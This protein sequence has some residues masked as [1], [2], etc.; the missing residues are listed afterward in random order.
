MSICLFFMAILIY[1]IVRGYR[2]LSTRI[3]LS[4]IYKHLQTIQ[5]LIQTNKATIYFPLLFF[6]LSIFLIILTMLS[7]RYNLIDKTR[8]LFLIIT[9]GTVSIFKGL[10]N[11]FLNKV[12]QRL[13]PRS[14]EQPHRWSLEFLLFQL[15]RLDIKRYP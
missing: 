2:K 9:S 4:I 14:F 12:P 5:S 15:L 10:L 11:K 1:S 13:I 6:L 3:W 7:V 8:M